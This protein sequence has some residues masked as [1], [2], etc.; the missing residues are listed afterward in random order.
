MFVT[1]LL[2]NPQAL[3]IAAPLLLIWLL[4]P[5]IAYWISRSQADAPFQL[6]TGQ[7]QELRTLARRTWLFFEQFVGPQDN[8]LPPDHFQESPRGVIAHRTSPTNVGMYLLS[9]IAA[10]DLG[11]LHTLELAL[12]LRATFDTLKQLERYRGHFLNWIDTQ[13]LHPL[14][15]RY[16]STVD[17]GNLAACLLALKQ[18]CLDIIDRPVWRWLRW[19][20]FLDTLDLFNEVVTGLEKDRP[21]T[22]T[23]P[24]QAQIESISQ[25]VLAGRDKPSEWSSILS[26]LLAEALPQ[27]D[28]L[29]VTWVEG[30]AYRLDTARLGDLRLY[31]ER[32]HHFAESMERQLDL[33][34]WLL[35][36]T[37]PPALFSQ[38]DLDPAINAA[39]QALIETW[40]AVAPA[41]SEIKSIY[42]EGQVRQLP[43]S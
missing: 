13:T 6:T 36:L 19:Q 42:Q 43:R 25:Q 12:R 17:S 39:W 4:S 2:V 40:P 24:I 16:V 1:I 22:S 35:P 33:L 20:G 5:E 23:G 38:P 31:A 7:R 15:P 32:L 18:S 29:L 37:R 30:E 14:P 27:L 28:Q 21:E 41:L 26:H 8:W 34:P 3:F 10:Y 11:Y 9:T